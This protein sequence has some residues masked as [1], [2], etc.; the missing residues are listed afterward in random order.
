MGGVPLAGDDLLRYI[1]IALAQAKDM[2]KYV[3]QRIKEDLSTRVI[4]VR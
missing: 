3:E 1:E 2:D 4:E